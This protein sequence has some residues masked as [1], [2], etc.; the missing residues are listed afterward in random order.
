M[1]TAIFAL[2]AIA[3]TIPFP[4]AAETIRQ[5]KP[6]PRLEIPFVEKE[7]TLDTSKLK[8]KIQVFFFWATWCQFCKARMPHLEEI[9]SAYPREVEVHLVNV[10]DD[11][12]KA[13]KYLKDNPSVPSSLF[14]RGLD[15]KTRASIRAIPYT[16]IL[17][18]EGTVV[19]IQ[20]GDRA[21]EISILKRKVERLVSGPSA[22]GD[23]G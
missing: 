19:Y 15:I 7:G 4:L 9:R 5:R 12:A 16:L 23:R 6:F 13:A 3:L 2:L 1:R 8:G 17:D 22:K 21:N 10:D 20:E 18:R 11:R 14:D